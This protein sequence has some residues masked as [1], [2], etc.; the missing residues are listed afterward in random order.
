MCVYVYAYVLLDAGCAP[1]ST[2]H[3]YTHAQHIHAHYQEIVATA[4]MVAS[5]NKTCTELAS[6]PPEQ[7][8]T[9]WWCVR[10]RGGGGGGINGW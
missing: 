5:F 8:V 4:D 2:R 9:R 10:A 6:L 7:V 1:L 3:M